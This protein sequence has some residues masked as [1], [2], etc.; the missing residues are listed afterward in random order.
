MYKWRRTSGTCKER[1]NKPLFSSLVTLDLPFSTVLHLVGVVILTTFHA[2]FS[3]KIIIVILS[4]SARISSF[5]GGGGRRFDW[6]ECGYSNELYL[7]LETFK[8]LRWGPI[9]G[10]IRTNDW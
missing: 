7:M 2:P 9:A 4:F 1:E 8:K 5:C 10:S 6:T 3:D